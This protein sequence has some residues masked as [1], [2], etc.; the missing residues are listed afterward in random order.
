MVLMQSG[1]LRAMAFPSWSLR[2]S[3]SGAMK[4]LEC[5]KTCEVGKT[6]QDRRKARRRSAA[7][8]RYTAERFN[9]EKKGGR[10]GI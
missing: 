1:A 9:E 2:A 8:M 7:G 4:Q 10:R 3:R 6:S 5:K